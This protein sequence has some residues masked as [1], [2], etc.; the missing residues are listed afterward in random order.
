M[1]HRRDGDR[2]HGLAGT[3]FRIDD[4]GGLAGIDEQ[5]G[6]GL[7]NAALCR[8]RLALQA[9]HHRVAASVGASV[10]DRRILS[11]DGSQQAVAEVRDELGQGNDGG[12]RI[13]GR[14]VGHRCFE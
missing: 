7:D 2:H 5:A 11:G 1:Q 3:H 10:V 4:G 6:D 14:R 12:G 13:V 8:E 9:F